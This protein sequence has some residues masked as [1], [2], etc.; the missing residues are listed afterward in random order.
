MHTN[1]TPT[2]TPTTRPLDTAGVNLTQTADLFAIHE[3]NA[4]SAERARAAAAPLLDLL[5]EELTPETD[6][7]IEDFLVRARRTLQLM[8]ERR[9]PWTQAFDRIRATFT[10]LE[11][12]LD[13]K[14]PESFTAALQAK[15][16][17]YGNRLRAL[18]QERQEKLRQEHLRLAAEL[19]AAEEA[20][21][22]A[23]EAAQLRIVESDGLQHP[24]DEQSDQRAREAFQQT[25]QQLAA[26]EQAAA[27]PSVELPKG[28]STVTVTAR[29]LSAYICL[30]ALYVERTGV[31]VDKLAQLRL[32]QLTTW[33]E[34]LCQ[35]TGEVV[36]HPELEYREQFRTVAR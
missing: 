20:A 7:Q 13:P 5:A 32:G 19:K 23:Q 22:K 11:A 30:L 12:Q 29:T 4:T 31:P 10:A 15:R 25:L 17:A 16:D 35:E 9:E 18:E 2:T 34:K 27:T 28:R 14:K 26:V 1:P 36:E 33:A 6:R 21:H 8:K 3:Q 24:E